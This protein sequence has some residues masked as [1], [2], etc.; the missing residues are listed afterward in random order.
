MIALLNIAV[1][2][3]LIGIAYAMKVIG[4]GFASGF[5]VGMWTFAVWF[6]LRHGVWP[7]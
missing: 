6:R 5:I 7:P 4:I 1:I 3:S 2:V